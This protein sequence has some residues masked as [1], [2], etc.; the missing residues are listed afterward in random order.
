MRPRTVETGTYAA[1]GLAL[2]LFLA[3]TLGCEPGQRVEPI[4]CAEKAGHRLCEAVEPAHVAELVEQDHAQALARPGAE[5]G[6]QQDD[7]PEDAP[8]HGEL[9]MLGFEQ[10][11]VTPDSDLSADGAGEARV[12]A[13][14]MARRIGEAGF[15]GSTIGQH[16]TCTTEPD[17]AGGESRGG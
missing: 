16:K 6:R 7:R 2:V 15:S 11:N 4:E 17:D 10:Q 9:V 8:G 12:N 1:L 3:G 5:G 13:R 14:G